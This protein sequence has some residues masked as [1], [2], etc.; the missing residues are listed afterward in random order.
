MA[1]IKQVQVDAATGLLK[2]LFDEALERAGRVWKIIHVMS[3]NPPVMRDS[4]QLYRTVMTGESPLSRMQRE[5]LAT[6]VSS[7]LGC[8]Y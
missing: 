2:Q 4:I 1:W 7:E 8:G 5:L 6:I 3:L